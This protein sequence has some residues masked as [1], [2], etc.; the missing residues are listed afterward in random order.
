MTTEKGDEYEQQN[1]EGDEYSDEEDISVIRCHYWYCCTVYIAG[2]LCFSFHW[3][4]FFFQG[5]HVEW[6][7][8]VSAG[9]GGVSISSEIHSIH[10]IEF[11][12]QILLSSLLKQV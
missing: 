1:D 10:G 12:L 8:V 5:S 2:K 6:F 11:D 7:D 9:A 4:F 3:L